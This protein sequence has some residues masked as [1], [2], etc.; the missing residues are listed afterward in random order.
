VIG[1]WS[2][3]GDWVIG[4]WNFKQ[5]VAGDSL[6]QADNVP[7]YDFVWNLEFGIWDLFRV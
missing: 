6:R 7:N 2:L 3:F 4:Y 5:G 1:N